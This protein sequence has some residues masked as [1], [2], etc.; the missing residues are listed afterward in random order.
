MTVTLPDLMSYA[1]CA[2]FAATGAMAAARRKH[3]VVTFAFFAALT[4][5]GGG[6]LRDLFLGAP[7][8]WI[9]DP[10]YLTVCVAT[11]VLVWLLGFGS[12]SLKAL[13]WL[14][15][16][17]MAAFAVLGAVKASSL[18]VGAPVAILMG[19]LTATAGGVIR[20]I[21]AGEPSVLLQREVY[22]TAALLA[23]AVTVLAAP[24]VGATAAGAAGFIAGLSLR[25]AAIR[26]GWSLPAYFGGVTGQA[27]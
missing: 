5:L 19:V 9:A 4:G 1:G 17:G 7:V 10:T 22:V 2:V 23:A 26:F 12:A 20:D 18:G 16:V 13:L 14:D 21:T 3:D 25:A 6:T 27:R 8:I 11:G 15:A 24:F